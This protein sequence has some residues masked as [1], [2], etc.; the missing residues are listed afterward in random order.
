MSFKLKITGQQKT[1]QWAIL[2]NNYS[3]SYILFIHYK[4]KWKQNRA[5][6]SNCLYTVYYITGSQ[7]YHKKRTQPDILI[8]SLA[9]LCWKYTLT[10]SNLKAGLQLSKN[11]CIAP[12]RHTNDGAWNN[13]SKNI[14]NCDDWVTLA[15]QNWREIIHKPLKTGLLSTYVKTL[16]QR[17]SST[18]KQS[19][20]WTSNP[21]VDPWQLI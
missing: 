2:V 10:V 19:D 15:L 17:A 1:S 8:A 7:I 18:S 12:L 20:M 3:H 9:C 16:R 5:K 4:V 6:F 14:S 21:R 11:S 13:F